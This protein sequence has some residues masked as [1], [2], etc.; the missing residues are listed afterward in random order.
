MTMPDVPHHVALI[1]HAIAVGCDVRNP[2]I[3]AEPRLWLQN[4]RL[5]YIAGC[6]NVELTLALYQL[7]FATLEPKQCEVMRTRDKWDVDTSAEK[8]DRNRLIGQTKIQN[9][10]IV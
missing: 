2:N 7:A 5:R 6:V 3:H 10:G 4:C 9:T 8:P 1:K